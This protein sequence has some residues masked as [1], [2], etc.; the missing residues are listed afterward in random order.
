MTIVGHLD[1]I[2]NGIVGGW[3][4]N[5]DSPSDVQQVTILLDGVNVVTIGADQFRHDL[6]SAGLGRH[7]FFVKLPRSVLLK[8]GHV[9]A[10]VGP[11]GEELDGGPLI[12]VPQDPSVRAAQQAAGQVPTADIMALQNRFARGLA[13]WGKSAFEVLPLYIDDA[14]HGRTDTRAR[15]PT[16][17]LAEIV[18]ETVSAY[19][20][21]E[22]P[23]LEN[24]ACSIIIPAYNNFE[25]TYKCIESLKETGA[26]DL[27]EIILADDASADALIFLGSLVSNLR[28]SRN[29][30]N[31]GFL[32]NC[33]RAAKMARGEII[34]FLNNDTIARPNWLQALLATFSQFDRVGVAGSKLLYDDGTLQEAGGLMWDDASAWNFGNRDDGRAPAYNYVREVDYVTGASI[35]VRRSLFDSF[36]G[37]DEVFTPAYCEDSDLCLKASSS[38]WRVL[39]QPF[40]EIIHLE[41]KSHGTDET[42]G[43]KAYQVANNEKLFE[44]WKQYLANN[45]R[46]GDRPWFNKDRRAIGRA[47]VI[48]VVTPTPDKDAGSIATYEQMLLLRDLGYKVS[49][50]PEDNFAHVGEPTRRLQAAGI[51]CVYGPYICSVDE[52]LE[53]FGREVD[54]VHV[55]R[56]NV[57]SKHLQTIKQRTPFAKLIFSNADMH[58]LRLSRQAALLGDTQLA[59]EAERV[60][61]VE[62]KFHGLADVS[63]VTSQYEV[64]L[65]AREL[66]NAPVKL[67]RWITD[68]VEPQPVYQA[69]DAIAFLGGYQ[70]PP[71][72]D[73][74]DHFMCHVLPSVVAR[75]PETKFLICGSAMPDRF[76]DYA[77]PNVEVVGFVPDLRQLFRRC[78]G[79]VAP[80]RYGAGFK[81]KVATSL[82]HGVPCIGTAIAIEG[83]GFEA[84]EGVVVAET[85][86]A[87][88]DAI[89]RLYRDPAEWHH[90]AMRGVAAVNR[91]YSRKAAMQIWCDILSELGLPC[92]LPPLLQEPAAAPEKI[93]VVADGGASPIHFLQARLEQS[94]KRAGLTR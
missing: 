35:A 3:A 14:L 54:I 68:V 42:K 10:T 34:V 12:L 63:I 58:F 79:T 50:I 94:R 11:H 78:V 29:S 18:E 51:E 7:S 59:Q 70:H 66:P 27:A 8:G 15:R 17:N 75:T 25:L 84:E 49:F 53:K 90:L 5:P 77:G 52:W 13:E 71:N 67:L 22:L 32:L 48:D 61:S 39:Y 69:R 26:T 41:G 43:I 81:G 56:H 16:A 55:Y 4:Y 60:G 65:L 24:P 47:V 80:L 31:L 28:V 92:V 45:G 73:A 21:I 36:G 93:E 87:F 19:P 20:V 74:V 6:D 64:D 37:F 2:E 76:Q 57:L 1:S 83:M 46:N 44:R 89:E 62:M 72:V 38:G 82:A 40:S 33:N 85:P 86:D 23:F 88:A 9:T 91:L 30:K